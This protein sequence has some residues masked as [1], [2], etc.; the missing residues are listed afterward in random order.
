MIGGVER[1][2]WLQAPSQAVGPAGKRSAGLP[3]I[4]SA[5]LCCY[6]KVR[7]KRLP[8]KTRELTLANVD[9]HDQQEIIAPR[10][11]QTERAGKRVRA[12][13]KKLQDEGVLDENGR[14]IRRDV[15][16]D[17]REGSEADFGG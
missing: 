6:S 4:E 13:V 9:L 2:L 14:R 15:P 16:P 12:A 11:Q 8:A 7:N 10:Q 3:D 5:H 1:Q 17:M